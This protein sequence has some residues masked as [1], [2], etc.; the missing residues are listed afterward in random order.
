MGSLSNRLRIAVLERDGYRCV[1]CGLTS[2]EATLQVDHVNPRA[3]GGSDDATNLV[4]A[5]FDCNNGK[6]A[7]LIRLPEHVMPGPVAYQEHPARQSRYVSRKTW[8]EE[9]E[10]RYPDAYD[11]CWLTGNGRYATVA[12]CAGLSV[13]LHKDRG[14]AERSLLT[15]NST[16]CGHGCWRDHEIIDM[17]I[18]ERIDEAVERDR[19]YRRAAH[20]SSCNTC[21]YVYDNRGPGDA[22]ERG[23]LRCIKAGRQDRMAT[24][25]TTA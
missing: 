8:K 18:E 3:L 22:V 4:A 16:S 20:F 11:M 19:M 5:C 12:W 23:S 24:R 10:H 2:A 1:Y 15:I 7:N 13:A 25:A 17:S 21:R 9:A 6:R 14:V